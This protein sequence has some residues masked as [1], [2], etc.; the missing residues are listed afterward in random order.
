MKQS[1]QDVAS[2]TP[3]MWS[4]EIVNQ[5]VN[6]NKQRNKQSNKQQNKQTSKQTSKQESKQIRKQV[7]EDLSFPLLLLKV[8][9][10]HSLVSE[11]TERLAD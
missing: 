3:E 11:L 1:K 9:V 4:K 7:N 2:K 5:T 6:N 10:L 8:F